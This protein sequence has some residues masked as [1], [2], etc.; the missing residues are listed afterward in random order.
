MRIDALLPVFRQRLAWMAALVFTLMAACRQPPPPVDPAA[1]ETPAA[2]TVLRHVMQEARAAGN[3]AQVG[4]IVLGPRLE[5][6]TPEFRAQFQDAGLQWFSTDNLT[7]V[8][9]GTVA[10][11]IEKTTKLQP[12]QLQIYSVE[13]RD[14]GAQEVIA[15]W[16]FEDK[17]V[18]RRYLATPQTDGGWHVEA[19]EVVE[20]KK[21]K[22][23]PF[24]Q[25]EAP[26]QSAD[27]PSAPDQ[28]P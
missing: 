15:A 19:L 26:S 2:A 3:T 27:Q 28:Q 13:N 21:G 6:S 5:D 20:E 9:V 25:P 17:M 18:R 12:L 10:R 11:V 24:V 1:F 22:T 7:H 23:P 8:W 14:D 4:V 16:A